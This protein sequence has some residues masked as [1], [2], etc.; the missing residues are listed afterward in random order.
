MFS[1]SIKISPSKLYRTIGKYD[2][3]LTII[4]NSE[5]NLVQSL[6]PYITAT[7]VYS[8]DER[9]IFEK[10]DDTFIDNYSK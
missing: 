9:K 3:V 1:N 8:K 2:S 6:A 5:S 7:L 4:F 10:N